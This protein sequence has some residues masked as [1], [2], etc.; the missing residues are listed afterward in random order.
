MFSVVFYQEPIRALCFVVFWDGKTRR[1]ICVLCEPI[2]P[3]V[4]AAEIACLS[5][6]FACLESSY[7]PLTISGCPSLLNT[8]YNHFVDLS[9]M[10]L[11][12]RIDSPELFLEH[13]ST[14]GSKAFG[15]VPPFK[16]VDLEDQKHLGDANEVIVRI[17]EEKDNH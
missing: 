5:R 14:A 3:E 17:V 4:A 8:A 12:F 6:L 9:Q 2:V 1:Q 11:V 16:V 7:R 15:I 13:V 10:L